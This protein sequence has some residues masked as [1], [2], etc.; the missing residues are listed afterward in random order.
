MDDKDASSKSNDSLGTLDDQ[1]CLEQMGYVQELYR[2]FGG[3]MSFAFCFTAVSVIPSIS[4][5]FTS[6]VGL[7][8]PAEIVWAWIV[9][10]FFC[11]LAGASM[12]EI[13]S[14]YPSA[15][16]VYH[17]A[18]Q[19]G[20]P[21]WAPISSYVCGWF[22]FLGNAAGDAAFSSGF[23]TCVSYASTIA[24]PESGELSVGAQVGISILV[25][26]VWSLLD[27]ARTDVQ[28]WIN[29]LTVF[30]QIAGS[31]VIV[32]CLLALSSERA[33][34][35]FVFLEGIDTTNVT[36]STDTPYAGMPVPAYT[37]VLG[38]TSCLFAFTGC[39]FHVKSAQSSLA[40]NLVRASRNGGKNSGGLWVGGV[41]RPRDGEGDAG[42]EREGRRAERQVRG[43]GAHGGGDA[44]RADGGAAGHHR[45]GAVLRG[46]RPRLHPRHALRHTRHHRARSPRT[47]PPRSPAPWCVW[48]GL[49]LC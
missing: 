26:A 29:N 43:R 46:V 17:W 34:G 2:G 18:G 42:Q 5:G 14:V 7:G 49:Y 28:G 6:S 13:S 47:G 27:C 35:S 20:P 1:R 3:F 40:E 48:G 12:A 30:W 36:L 25:L 4:L 16:S 32:I 39:V 31:L 24:D 15:G 45:D 38:I 21:E 11:I 37:I 22:N 41:H 10:S 33:T 9:G 23:A 44:G 8:G 19:M